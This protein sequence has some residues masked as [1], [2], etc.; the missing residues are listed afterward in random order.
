MCFYELINGTLEAW[1]GGSAG[2]LWR[3]AGSRWQL[4]E[5]HGDVSLSLSLSPSFS[6]TRPLKRTHTM[7]YITVT[8]MQS[9]AAERQMTIITQINTSALSY[10]P[11]H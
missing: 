4:N 7:L 9:S 8:G 2:R 6:L 10:A 3:G 5:H 1:G 11:S